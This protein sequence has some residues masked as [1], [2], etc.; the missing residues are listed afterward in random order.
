MFYPRTW[1]LPKDRE[2]FYAENKQ[3]DGGGI[4]FIVKPQG[5]SKGNGI[6]LAT[7]ID[8]ID[9]SKE[10]VVQKYISNPLLLDE[11]Q[12]K[13]DLRLYVLIVSINPLQI[14]LY[15]KGL[16]RFASDTY[17]ND[18]E[19]I[20]TLCGHLTNF[21]I[22]KESGD[23]KWSLQQFWGIL[24][25]KHGDTKDT[26]D[27]IKEH[28][29]SQVREMIRS[30]FQIANKKL[31]EGFNV[32]FGSD[33]KHRG[34]CFDLLGMD[35]LIDTDFKAYLLEMNRYPSLKCTHRV[36]E[37]VKYDLCND[38]MEMLR[39]RLICNNAD[40]IMFHH[41]PKVVLRSR[42]TNWKRII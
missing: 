6:S 1:V 11:R 13:F 8:E 40:N 3:R 14:Y 41:N 16:V 12:R 18:L 28:I 32:V 30:V 22:N 24:A 25:E 26:K 34:R 37:E 42:G 15:D 5:K 36:D 38:M 39:P 27:T 21:A 23:I 17:S 2:L 20:N 10:V 19:D 35:V 7:S 4:K 29:L 9:T 31:N 33:K